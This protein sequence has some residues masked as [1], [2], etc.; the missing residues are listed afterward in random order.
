[1][2]NLL[3]QKTALTLASNAKAFLAKVN[4]EEKPSKDRKFATQLKETL[5]IDQS[6]DYEIEGQSLERSSLTILIIFTRE[7]NIQQD[8]MG[9]HGLKS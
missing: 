8:F 9:M 3:S 4:S 7:M 5:Q 6:P 1:M 2:P